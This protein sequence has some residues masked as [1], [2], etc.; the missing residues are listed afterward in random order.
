[1]NLISDSKNTDTHGHGTH[2]AGTIGGTFH[3]VAKNVSIVGVK[4]YP[5]VP[6]PTTT[7]SKFVEALQ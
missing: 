1:M 3:G 7:T 6:N 4:V 2:V 5:D